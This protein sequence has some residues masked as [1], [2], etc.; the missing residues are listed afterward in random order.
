MPKI[1][2]SDNNELDRNLNQSGFNELSREEITALLKKAARKLGHAPSFRE[3]ERLAGATRRRI[4]QLFGGYREF[5]AAGSFEAQGAGYELTTEQ[6]FSDWASV[7]RKLGKI[8]SVSQYERTGSYSQGV[9]A[10]RWGSWHEIPETM[11]R[12][13]EEMRLKGKWRDVIRMAKEH[14][15]ELRR[16]EEQKQAAARPVKRKR[17]AGKTCNTR[18]H[19][20]GPVY[21]RPILHPAMATAP[22]NE[23]GV[24]LLFAAMAV[25]LG[26]LILRAQAGFP[27]CEALRRCGKDCWRWVRIEFEYESRN[28]AAH[29][30]DR[31]GCDLIVCWKHNWAGCP[32]E[33]LE[34]SKLVGA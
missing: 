9:F 23:A 29:R 21:G 11:V 14:K 26:F 13:A 33:V 4:M 18:R 31:H 19:D 2:S 16:K 6:L 3:F 24:M 27:D 1:N 15:A 7:V 25:Q 12:F 32:V 20:S 17:S 34:L 10:S 30:H 5:L 8:P 28:F 22:V